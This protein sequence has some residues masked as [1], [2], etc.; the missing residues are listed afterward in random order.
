MIEENGQYIPNSQKISNQL[1]TFHECDVN[2]T[3]CNL[4]HPLSAA[5]SGRKTKTQRAN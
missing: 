5:L 1:L 2:F 4:D 3:P